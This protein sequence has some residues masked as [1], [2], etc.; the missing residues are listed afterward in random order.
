M[1][2]RKR[3]RS[4]ETEIDIAADFEASFRLAILRYWMAI[5]FIYVTKNISIKLRH[6]DLMSCRILI[7]QM[8]Q[9]A[10][11]FLMTGM[12]VQKN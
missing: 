8:P 11:L 2:E 3:K 10:S 4:G 9:L 12:W 1:L 5:I 7:V 6:F